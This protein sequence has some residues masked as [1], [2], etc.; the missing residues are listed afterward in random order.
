VSGKSIQKT[1]LQVWEEMG[2]IHYSQ[3]TGPSLIHAIPQ[4]IKANGKIIQFK[5]EYLVLDRGV[6]ICVHNSHS[7]CILTALSSTTIANRFTDMYRELYC[8]T[9]TSVMPQPH[10]LKSI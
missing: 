5:C 2:K 7:F 4:S 3:P 10:V 8:H 6:H 1:K 9:A